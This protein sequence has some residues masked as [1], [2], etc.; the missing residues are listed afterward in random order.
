MKTKETKKTDVKSEVKVPKTANYK[1]LL[2][3][4]SKDANG[5]DLIIRVLKLG[6]NEANIN[7]KR[8]VKSRTDD[9]VR[10]EQSAS[11]LKSEEWGFIHKN[12]AAVQK[13]LDADAKVVE[14]FQKKQK[15][16]EKKADAAKALK[17][18]ADAKAKD[19]KEA[20]T[21]AA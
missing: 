13:A 3:L 8:V 18:K 21:K 11:H 15:A 7:L 9:K 1:T 5:N 14:S 12:Y 20:K 6:D 19:D 10:R 2:E 4:N 17:A 16:D